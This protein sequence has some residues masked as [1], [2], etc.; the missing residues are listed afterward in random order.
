MNPGDDRTLLRLLA[1]AELTSAPPALRTLLIEAFDDPSGSERE[2]ARSAL[3]L[4]K[5]DS[6]FKWWLDASASRDRVAAALSEPARFRGIDDPLVHTLLR[7]AIVP[8]V[9]LER[10]VRAL[11]RAFLAGAPA[12]VEL[13]LSVAMQCANTEYVY[14]VSDEERTLVDALALRCETIPELL[15]VAMFEPIQNV[16][17]ARRLDRDSLPVSVKAFL[18]REV[19]DRDEEDAIRSSI[20]RPVGGNAVLDRVRAQY[21]GAPYPRWFRAP[22][23]QPRLFGEMVAKSIEPFPL[24]A[25]IP[26]ASDILVAGCGTGLD[27]ISIASGA[28]SARVLAVD[29]SARSLA[30]AVRMVRRAGLSNVEF[31]HADL[32]ELT[33]LQRSFDAIASWGVLHHLADPEGGL[34]VLASVLRPD[35]IIGI[36]LYSRI[37]RAPIEE[38]RRRYR[39]APDASDE[40]IRRLRDEI[41]ADRRND[42][43]DDFV[44]FTLSELR[45]LLFHVHERTFTLGD[46]AA[47]IDRAGLEFIGFHSLPVPA[48]AGHGLHTDLRSWDRFEREHPETFGGLYRFWC[49]KPVS[50]R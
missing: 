39:L 15:T 35:G 29:A 5:A 47:M 30:Y 49:R 32:M 14:A 28:P 27:A 1:H 37:G 16:A 2:L 21:E 17:F 45:D 44:F 12:H 36:G 33:S 18:D 19:D 43:Q 48:L 3:T 24:P 42:M 9:D 41:L 4:L 22:R 6:G 26:E 46:I 34:S 38:I 10:L 20:E 25:A 13:M 23:R 7:N 31:L 11:R 8:D 50:P 40:D